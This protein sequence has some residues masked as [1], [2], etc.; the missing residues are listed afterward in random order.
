MNLYANNPSQNELGKFLSLV[1]DVE[2]IED[3]MMPSCIVDGEWHDIREKPVDYAIFCNKVTGTYVEHQPGGGVSEMK[4][5]PK[6]EER[7]GKLPKAWFTST[8]GTFDEL[9]Y[10]EYLKTGKMICSWDCGPIVP[11][12]VNK[13]NKDIEKLKKIREINKKIDDL[14]GLGI[15]DLG[16]LQNVD[17][18]ELVES[19]KEKVDRFKIDKI[20]EK[21]NIND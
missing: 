8:D 10:E 5:V 14:G 1:S 16:D 2:R 7:Y 21:H 18:D 15:A 4:W 12:M 19:I 17:E 9:G 6:Y 3:L 13:I 20:K 11:E